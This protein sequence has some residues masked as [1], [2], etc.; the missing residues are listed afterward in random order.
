MKMPLFNYPS[1]IVWVDDSE[2]FIRSIL[3]NSHEFKPHNVKT[4]T[5]PMECLNFFNNINLPNDDGNFLLSCKNYEESDLVDHAPTDIDFAKISLFQEKNKKNDEISVIIVDQNM[6]GISGID[7]CNKLKHLPVKKILLT[8]S[9][10]EDEVIKAF[11][12][13]V[14]DCYIR[15][16]SDTFIE[17]I[18]MHA[19]LLAEKYFTEKSSALLSHLEADKK[20]HFSDNYFISFFAEWCKKNNIIEYCLIDKI[21]NMRVIDVEGTIRNFIIYNNETLNEFVYLNNLA[22]EPNAFL[23]VISSKNKI[24]FFGERKNGWD[25]AANDW[26]K[27]LYPCNVINGRTD[28]YW[29]V[30]DSKLNHEC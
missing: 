21:G 7:L 8:G 26:D 10:A 22:D 6:P 11:N 20:L 3:N 23:E 25:I 28:Y 16:G 17:E 29:C 2:I 24:P 9:I 30:I 18:K 5:S 27:Y 19:N 1:T 12:G 13:K 4:F 15:K 14:I